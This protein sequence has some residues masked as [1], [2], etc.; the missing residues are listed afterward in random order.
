MATAAAVKAAAVRTSVR[1]TKLVYVRMLGMWDLHSWIPGD[2]VSFHLA[3]T[4]IS[5]FL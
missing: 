3:V 5:L 2:A 4:V 1:S